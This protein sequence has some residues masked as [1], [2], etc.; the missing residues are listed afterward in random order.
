MAVEG[1]VWSAGASPPRLARCGGLP[2]PHCSPLRSWVHRIAGDGEQGQDGGQAAEQASLPPMAAVSVASCMMGGNGDGDD[3]EE[4]EEEAT[5][6]PVGAW[7]RSDGLIE[8]CRMR[9]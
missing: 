2:D 4:E 3:E 6:Q 8:L 1:S 5:Y 9:C 7:V